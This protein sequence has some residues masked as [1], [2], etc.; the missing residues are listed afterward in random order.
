[1]DASAAVSAASVAVVDC[2]LLRENTTGVRERR[3]KGGGEEL[4]MT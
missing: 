1:M 3:R 2:V 4:G